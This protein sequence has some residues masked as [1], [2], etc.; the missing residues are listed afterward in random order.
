MPGYPY[1][2][3]AKRVIIQSEIC[4]IYVPINCQFRLL[5]LQICNFS[6]EKNIA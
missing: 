2:Y 3:A 1:L 4:L 6:Y 5:I